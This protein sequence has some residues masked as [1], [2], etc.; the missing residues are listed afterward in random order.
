V[1]SDGVDPE[2]AGEIGYGLGLRD[3]FSAG[4]LRH[5]AHGLCRGGD[6]GVAFSLVA[7]EDSREGD[8]CLCEL[9]LELLNCL[10]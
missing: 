8:V 3:S 1:Q 6:V 2:V 10:C 4:F 9:V 7:A 5:E